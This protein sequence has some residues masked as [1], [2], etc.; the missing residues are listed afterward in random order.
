MELWWLQVAR[1]RRQCV[2]DLK[3]APWSQQ[4]VPLVAEFG[5]IKGLL[6]HY[7]GAWTTKRKL[8][9]LLFWDG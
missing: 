1:L 6:R 9:K 5:M 2:M 8:T 7:Q 3:H 4:G